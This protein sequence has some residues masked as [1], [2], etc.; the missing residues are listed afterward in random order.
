VGNVSEAKGVGD[1]VRALAANPAMGDGATLDILGDGDLEG[2]RKLAKDLKVEGRVHF[3][4]RVPHSTVAPAM[5]A[6]DA[7]LVYSRHAYGEG[8]PGTIYLGLASRTPL[9]ISDHP[10]FKAYFRDGADALVVPERN[11][12]ALASKLCKLFEDP[13]LYQKLS[14]NSLA[15]FN[16]ILHPVHWG[17]FIERWLHDTQDDRDWLTSNT[18]PNWK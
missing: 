3:A 12:R 11:P 5:H 1:I 4:G 17:E 14:Q 18:L 7:V 13:I 15:N 2:I 9:I 10:M 8:L 16:R 6:A